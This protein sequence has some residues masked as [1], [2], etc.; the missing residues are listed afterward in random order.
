MIRYFYLFIFL[1]TSCKTHQLRFKGI[2][3]GEEGTLENGVYIPLTQLDMKIV[4]RFYPN[5]V[6]QTMVTWY[7][8][9]DKEHVFYNELDSSK[10]INDA[11]NPS[12]RGYYRVRK[13]SLFLD[14]ISSNEKAEDGKYLYIKNHE[15]GTVSKNGKRLKLHYKYTFLGDTI[16]K[17]SYYNFLKVW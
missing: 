4:I 14:M 9:N 10:Y 2:Y 5:G 11:F 8:F 1:L 17:Y 13:D 15:I 6:H 12:P 16:D 7:K 3:Y